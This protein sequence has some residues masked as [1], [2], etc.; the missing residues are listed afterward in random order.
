MNVLLATIEWQLDRIHPEPCLCSVEPQEK[1]NKGFN[2]LKPERLSLRGQAG[3]VFAYSTASSLGLKLVPSGYPQ[4]AK[5]AQVR[6]RLHVSQSS[7]LITPAIAYTHNPYYM[8]ER[9]HGA[10]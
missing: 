9:M 6:R 7:P 3:Q 5:A 1:V 8:T 2:H 4:C 10:A